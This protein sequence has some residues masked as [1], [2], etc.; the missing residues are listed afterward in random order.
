MLWYICICYIVCVANNIDNN[1][2]KHVLYICLHWWLK[3]PKGRQ[4]FQS[5]GVS[6]ACW[7]TR[8][9]KDDMSDDHRKCLSVPT[10]LLQKRWGATW[11]GATATHPD[12]RFHHATLGEKE[13]TCKVHVAEAICS[14][15]CRDHF[16]ILAQVVIPLRVPLSPGGMQIGGL[17]CS[18]KLI[19]TK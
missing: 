8:R 12:E 11:C 7:R 1:N 15:P 19:H 3:A 2:N 6:G 16:A 5:H 17:W 18:G 13:T 10:P 9:H 14:L 4:I